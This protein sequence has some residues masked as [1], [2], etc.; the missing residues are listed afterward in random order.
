MAITLTEIGGNGSQFK[1]DGIPDFITEKT[2]KD[3]INLINK[4]GGGSAG[5]SSRQTV[6]NAGSGKGTFD[7]VKRTANEFANN[8]KKEN[9]ERSGLVDNL[10]LERGQSIFNRKA[11]ASLGRSF[12]A[13]SSALGTAGFVLLRTAATYA[14]EAMMKYVGTM[15]A[16]IQAGTGFALNVNGF[17]NDLATTATGMGMSFDEL[18]GVLN[19]FSGVTALNA[20]SFSGL[21]KTVTDVNS[22][23]IKFGYSAAEAAEFIGRET[24]FRINQIG[25]I[26]VGSK[27]FE[28]A[29]LESADRAIEYAQ[30]LGLSVNEFVALRHAAVTS[31]DA[32][33]GLARGSKQARE[34][35]L[36]TMTK[37]ADE[38]IRVGGEAGGQI[39]AA[40]IDAAGKGA[41]GFSD[42]AVGI[43]RA[44]P[45][46][47]KEFQNLRMGLL[48]GELNEVEMRERMSK[49]LGNQ[50]EAT[51]QR[52]FIL[53]RAGDESATKLLEFTNNFERA[54]TS[55]SLFGF[56]AKKLAQDQVKNFSQFRRNMDA[57]RNSF[58]NFLITLFS[59]ENAIKGMNTALMNLMNTLIPGSAT[60]DGFSNS[61][62]LNAEKIKLAANNFGEKFGKMAIRMSEH[63]EN[64]VRSLRSSEDN[65][66]ADRAKEAAQNIKFMQKEIDGRKAR[67]RDDD[68]LSE[69]QRAKILEQT[70]ALENGIKSENK[71]IDAAQNIAGVFDG[72]GKSLATFANVLGGIVDKMEIILKVLGLMVLGPM[73]APLVTRGTR[74]AAGMT[75]TPAGGRIT[76]AGLYDKR[77]NAYKNL[78]KSQ[79][80]LAQTRPGATALNFM[81]QT[82]TGKALSSAG[83]VAGPLSLAFSGAD[84][85]GDM[86]A[87]S[88]DGQMQQ[89][90]D[91]IETYARRAEGTGGGIGMA[92]GALGFLLGPV[93]FLTTAAAQMVGDAIGDG[94]TWS[95]DEIDSLRTDAS[96]INQYKQILTDNFLV[97]FGMTADNAIA[98]S[99][100]KFSNILM[101]SLQA[102]DKYLDTQL[103]ILEEDLAMTSN[104]KSR[105][106]I[107][108]DIDAIKDRQKE[109]MQNS[110][111]QLGID[112]DAQ[113]T[114]GTEE[115]K[116][117]QAILNASNTD[118]TDSQLRAEILQ[119]EQANYLRKIH[120][121]IKD[122]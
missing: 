61:L 22:P 62:T 111:K 33:I 20:R 2:A 40:F 90:R 60:I 100:E 99:S 46:M 101:E 88:R 11:A 121:V 97:P 47:N 65:E 5:S 78:S 36:D 12:G 45:G 50:S 19:T 54:K 95:A 38:M 86:L 18:A 57:V 30:V 31:G 4:L 94:L 10:K 118:N 3:L 8:L 13:L 23:L 104:K 79:Q 29:M 67:L 103:S 34:M 89:G 56:T 91:I 83:R 110:A 117:Q 37:F 82:K 39:A 43:V 73:I 44:L 53:A 7:D 25:M 75:R 52:L 119:Q 6:K 120:N 92:I 96:N 68:T 24:E 71:H 1:V 26:D 9:R 55:I 98:K 80:A 64:F 108:S 113:Y 63:I 109:L 107:Q 105:K 85:I 77:G 59:N 58:G 42:A 41:L 72:I 122:M 51:R 70:K 66:K 93:G 35:Q 15:E 16:S 48:T 28:S 49:L 112:L 114:E 76:N 84:V 17:A 21:I 27:S 106:S 116:K 115:Y 102:E 69:D 32:L 81:G 14:G 87:G 74:F